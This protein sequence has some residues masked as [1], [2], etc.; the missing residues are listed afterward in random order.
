MF[1]RSLIAVRKSE[2]IA[3]IPA[4][5][6]ARPTLTG[7]SPSTLSTAGSEAVTLT[8][9]GFSGYEAQVWFDTTAAT[10]VVVVDDETITCV[11]P[12]HA[13]GAIYVVMR[14]Q[15]GDDTYA[16]TYSS[17][18]SGFRILLETGDDLLMETGDALRLE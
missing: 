1:H 3:L 17:G 8:G 12:A 11:S 6:L 9:T 2:R 18:G 13:A 15:R 16:A 4:D 14:S 7:V 5:T 10:S